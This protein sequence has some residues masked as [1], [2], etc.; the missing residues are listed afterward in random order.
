MEMRLAAL[1]MVLVFTGGDGVATGHEDLVVRTSQ[2]NEYT[3]SKI[4]RQLL[5]FPGVHFSGYDVRSSCLLIRYDRAQVA[6]ARLLLEAL[7]VL[8]KPVRFSLVY[9]Y[10]FYEIIDGKLL[11]EGDKRKKKFSR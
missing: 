6:S 11:S 4:R 3:V 9:G 7:R 2:L 8:N 5:C 10:T 1:L